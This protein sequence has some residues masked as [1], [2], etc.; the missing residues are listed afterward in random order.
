MAEKITFLTR[1]YSRMQ[2]PIN[3][4]SEFSHSGISH[5]S[6]HSKLRF[7]EIADLTAV[8]PYDA[9]I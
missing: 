4:L 2:T 7:P 6:C 5:T 8:M 9:F 1:K 3:A